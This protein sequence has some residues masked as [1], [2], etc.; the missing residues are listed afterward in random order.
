MKYRVPVYYS[1]FA[2]IG[3]ACE[4]TC[5]RGWQIAIDAKSYESYRREPGAFGQRLRRE[6]DHGSRTFA[7]K[8]RDCAFLNEA[9]LCDIY[10]ELGRDRLCRTCRTY[11]RHM[12]DYGDVREVMLSLSCPEAARLILGDDSQGTWQIRQRSVGQ[13]TEQERRND[14]DPV[15]LSCVEET[16]HTIV[17]LIKDRSVDFYERL[18]M[19]VSYAHDVQLHLNRI[20]GSDYPHPKERMRRWVKRISGRY[21]APKAASRFL[22]RL[23]PFYGRRA[24]RKLRM[25]AWMRL[26]QELEPVLYHWEEKQGAVCTGLYH[27]RSSKEYEA[28]ER[29]F[30]REARMLE[31]EWENLLLYFIYSYLLG[32][33]YDEDLYGKVK[34]AVFSTMVIREWCMFRFGITGV[35]EQ[36]DLV[37]AS[38]RYSREVENSDANLE[39]L[40]TQ[41]AENPLFHLN[42][43][44]TVLVGMGQK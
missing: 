2:C 22:I 21:L 1:D 6:I 15:L 23:E 5:C 39:F 18:A 25:T 31:Q 20:L 17:C 16:R 35:L 12:E 36:K 40:E 28:L 30:D 7:L 13:R 24:E 19:I 27:R 42:S 41:F 29:A 3:A 44:L 38:Y 33:C 10:R 11:P 34:L 26:L 4:D 9:G 32:A 14:P 43:M 37:A 8:G